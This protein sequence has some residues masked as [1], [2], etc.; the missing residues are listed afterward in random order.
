MA[1][2]FISPAISLGSDTARVQPDFMPFADMSTM[3]QTRPQARMPPNRLS[4]RLKLNCMAD[5]MQA[6][7]QAIF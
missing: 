4:T 5:A 7:E 3:R 2:R 1:A 6:C